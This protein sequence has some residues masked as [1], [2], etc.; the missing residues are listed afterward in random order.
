MK[1]A[2]RTWCADD[3][4]ATPDRPP[5]AVLLPGRVHGDAV[6]QLDD[7]AAAPGGGTPGPAHADASGCRPP[8]LRRLAVWAVLPQAG[9]G[10]FVG[11]L[12]IAG[13]AWGMR[14]PLPAFSQVR[15]LQSIRTGLPR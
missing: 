9:C 15:G 11:I 2:P 8:G 14:L 5:A 13:A 3:G 6:L 4:T 7:L 12:K 1:S 10:D